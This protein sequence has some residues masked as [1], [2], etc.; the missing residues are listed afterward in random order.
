VGKKTKDA[1][2]TP[3]TNTDD[4]RKMVSKTSLQRSACQPIEPS[5]VYLQS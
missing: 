5:P 2:P 3:A 1:E 4:Q